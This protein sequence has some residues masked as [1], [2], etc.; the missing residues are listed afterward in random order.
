MALTFGPS[1]DALLGRITVDA[2]TRGGRPVV[3]NH[4]LAVDH[5]LG[6]LATG[7]DPDAIVRRHPGLELDDVRACLAYARR[8]VEALPA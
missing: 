7:D 1:E 8:I 2:A 6:L 4:G 3:R 5:V